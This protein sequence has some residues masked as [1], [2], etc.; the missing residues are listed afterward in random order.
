MNIPIRRSVTIWSLCLTLVLSLAGILIWTTTASRVH[1]QEAGGRL[2]T[3]FDRG[4]EQVV[5]STGNTIGDALETAGIEIDAR[6][7][8]EPSLDEPMIASE[9]QVNIYRARPVTI[10]DGARSERVMTAYQTPEQIVAQAEI[11][12]HAEDELTTRRSSDLLAN[13]AGLQLV[14]DR[15]TPFS[16]DLFGSETD[17]RT[18]G[19]TV[20]EMLAEKEITLGSN[21]RVRPAA[22]TPL[23]EGLEVRVWREGKQTLTVE[24]EVEFTTKQ[25]KDADQP[26][27]YRKV[28]TPG[29]DGLR[30]VTYEIHIK[31]GEEVSRESIASLTLEEAV[32]QVEVIGTKPDHLPYTG[33]GSKTDWLAASNIP[34]ESWGYADF[35]VNRES[36]WN[37]NAVNPS[38]GACGLA[39]AL[40][41]S[42]VPGNPHDPV[43]SLN[44]MN[45]YVNGRYG[46]WEGAYNFWTANHWY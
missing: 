13:G 5:L 15:A 44:W 19:E 43:N 36:S 29:K 42:K 2:V 27:G 21:D 33:G 25:I 40:P 11:S 14:I 32:E 16:F 4:T 38:S 34:R 17:A 10:I 45:G 12:L 8:V 30:K 18:Q 3:I 6:D 28:Q 1:A 24:E 37:P 9:Y 7:V 41:C 39:Q 31:N 46:G 22:E 20:G 35:M 23:T 26:V